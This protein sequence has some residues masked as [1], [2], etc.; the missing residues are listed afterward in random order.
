[1]NPIT[2]NIS[3]VSHVW[4]LTSDCKIPQSIPH[5][6]QEAQTVQ[7]IIFYM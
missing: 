4:P 5:A 3:Q 6:A 1:M 2:E 7:S